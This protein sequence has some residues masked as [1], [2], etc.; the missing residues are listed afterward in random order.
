M[1]QRR[2]L[3]RFSVM[4]FLF[5]LVLLGAGIA[6]REYSVL[7]VKSVRLM[8]TDRVAVEQLP[9][10]AGQ[11]L[12]KVDMGSLAA[13]ALEFPFVESARARANYEGK[14]TVAVQE[15]EPVAMVYCGRLYGITE[16]CELLPKELNVRGRQLPVIRLTQVIEIGEF[17][18]LDDP[19][20][21][22]ALSVLRDLERENETIYARLS[23]VVASS[24]GLVLI[25]EPGSIVV[26]FGWGFTDTK[27]AQLE[28][29]LQSNKNPGLDI[30]LRFAEMAIVRSRNVNREVNNGI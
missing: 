15:K 28:K 26:D 11:N 19:A 23:E 3:R 7:T 17:E 20:V 25:L 27:A 8:G 12:L 14:V 2:R 1:K 10:K 22:A 21:R 5:A 6:A 4:L 16:R 24:D 30:D 9:V 29:I 18:T 13:A